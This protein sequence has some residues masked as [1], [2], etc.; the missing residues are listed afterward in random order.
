MPA[1]FRSTRAHN[2]VVIDGKSQSE[3]FGVFGYG[4]LAK[5]TLLRHELSRDLDYA[6]ACHDGY[7]P[8]QHIRDVFFRKGDLSYLLIV[9]RL[10]SRDRRTANAFFHLPHTMRI[11]ENFEMISAAE[12]QPQGMAVYSSVPIEQRVI[13]GQKYPTYQG[14]V[15]PETKEVEPADTLETA[16]EFEE[17][18]YLA[19]LFT[20]K[21]S[22]PTLSI[23]DHPHQLLV[24]S[25]RTDA[26][27]INASSEFGTNYRLNL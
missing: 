11:D 20:T 21:S 5:V 19:F 15:S 4:R 6:S 2:T 23:S 10:W 12:G 7:A 9:D 14:W 17:F 26:Y 22:M 13:H 18:A 16:F 8:V 25:N 3:L 24:I 27:E 1:F